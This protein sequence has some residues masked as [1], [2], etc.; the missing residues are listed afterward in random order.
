MPISSRLRS[1]FGISTDAR[2][3]GGLGWA[4]IR[5]AVALMEKSGVE[6]HSLNGPLF[7]NKFGRFVVYY[8]FYTLTNCPLWGLC[9]YRA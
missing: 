1:L 6:G 3:A 9:M 7:R 8:A 4:D 2:F 5:R